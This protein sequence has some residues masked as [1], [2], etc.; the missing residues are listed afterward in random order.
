MQIF[1]SYI[2]IIV[3][4]LTVVFYHYNMAPNSKNKKGRKLFFLI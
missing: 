2:I 4:D 1:V 3:A